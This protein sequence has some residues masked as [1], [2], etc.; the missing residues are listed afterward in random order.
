MPQLERVITITPWELIPGISQKEVLNHLDGDQLIEYVQSEKKMI[1]ARAEARAN[2][3]EIREDL[4]FKEE[5]IISAAEVAEALREAAAA[6]AAAP[7]AEV[8]TFTR[9]R[10]ST[11]YGEPERLRR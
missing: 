5:I 6:T 3:F 11:F 4:Q 7:P 1:R 10:V 2:E 9:E 8:M